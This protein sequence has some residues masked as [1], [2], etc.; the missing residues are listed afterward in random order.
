MKPATEGSS[1]GVSRLSK[2]RRPEDLEPSVLA[3]HTKWPTADILIERFLSGREITV[4]IFGEGDTARALGVLEFGFTV[5]HIPEGEDFQHY[6]QRHGIAGYGTW[7]KLIDDNDME[8]P[9]IRSACQAALAAYRVI[10]CRDAGRV[11]TRMDENGVPHIIEVCR[12][13]LR[14]VPP[15]LK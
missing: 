9:V 5:A 12:G 13:L 4:A 11:D 15:N 2:I 14:L 3:I 10:G 1:K 8:D 6:E 7:A